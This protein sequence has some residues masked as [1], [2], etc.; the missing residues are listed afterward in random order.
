[1]KRFL[2]IIL[3]FVG[4]VFFVGVFFFVKNSK[5]SNAVVSDGEAALVEVPL[6]ERPVVS[7]I[8]S[9]DGHYLKLKI[10]K[11]VVKGSAKLDY[12]LEYQTSNDIT[13]G[14]PG[15][16]DLNG[17]KSFET[18]IL[19]G[20][21]S[22]GKYRYD[23]G[24]EIGN[25]EIKL[26]DKNGKLLTKFDTDFHIQTGVAELTSL[27]GKFTYVLDKVP[28]GVIFVTMQTIGVPEESFSSVVSKDGYSVFA[29]SGSQ[30]A[31]TVKEN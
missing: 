21:E 7:I 28:K 4:V 11:I 20:T 12:L 17:D 19:L 3:F 22:S 15:V 31:G 16:K 10:D 24:V 29:S 14:V 2:P 5:S 26:R 1:M 23:E 25:V 8:P 6:D 13:Q 18:D 9:E 30:Y 27:D